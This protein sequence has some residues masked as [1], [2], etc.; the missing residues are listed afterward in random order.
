MSQIRILH[1]FGSLSRG[2][3]E[4]RTIEVMRCCPRDRFAF[5]CLSISGCA[6]ELD[7]EVKLLGGRVHLYRRG[8]SFGMQLAHLLLKGNYD[9]VHS[10]VLYYS[11][12]IL[13]AARR[14]G[15]LQRIAH[16]RSSEAN[17]PT[18]PFLRAWRQIGRDLISQNATIIASVSKAAM[19]GS[20]SEQWQEDPRCRIIYNG[21]NMNRFMDKPDPMGVRDELGLPLGC[22]LLIHVGN[23]LPVKNHRRLLHIYRDL[24]CRSTDIALL[25]VGDGTREMVKHLQPTLPLLRALGRRDDVARLL[26]AADVQVHTSFSEGL[27]GAVLEGV[28]ANLPIIGSEI[29]AIR[30]IADNCDLIECVPLNSSNSSWISAIDRAFSQKVLLI[31]RCNRGLPKEFSFE[32]SV[33]Q[34]QKLW[35]GKG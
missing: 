4:L 31:G 23:A 33:V 13:R 6:A 17:S 30:E 19:E 11:G 7:A 8:P 22:K 10:H 2:G 21:I 15:V 25:L 34:M 28:A 14:A 16:F 3:A 26:L 29:P 18:S 5:D 9:V 12:F 27:P 24:V 20:W 1:V 35:E 32:R